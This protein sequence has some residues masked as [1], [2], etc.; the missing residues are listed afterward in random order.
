[1]FLKPFKNEIKIVLLKLIFFSNF[2]F[3]VRQSLYSDDIIYGAPFELN[4]PNL[5]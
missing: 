4:L 2:N 5:I 1:M 3:Y